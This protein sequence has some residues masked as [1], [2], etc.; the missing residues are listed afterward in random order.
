MVWIPKG[1]LRMGADSLD[2]F[3]NLNEF[4]QHDVRISS[5]FWMGRTEVTQYQFEAI[6]GEWEF[7]FEG[8]PNYPAET[9]SWNTLEQLF[10]PAL[11][12]NSTGEWRLP[13]EAEW[14]YAY[15]AG[16][17]SSWYW[18]D[19]IDSLTINDYCW[20]INN[21]P[22]NEHNEITPSVVGLK[23]PNTWNLYDMAGNVSELT[24]DSYHPNYNDAPST[25]VPWIWDSFYNGCVVRGGSVVGEYQ[26][27]RASYREE[28]EK[29][30][31]SK[32]IG[33]RLVYQD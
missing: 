33:F 4:P 21:S 19:E 24:A 6:L 23:L 5:G 28:F 17:T 13:S 14:E 2:S 22:M 3:A 7:G 25:E 1:S 29:P 31:S 9:V 11:N 12:Q 30:L 32:R 18:S 27:L 20:N 10:L 16:S 15:R 26:H 8:N